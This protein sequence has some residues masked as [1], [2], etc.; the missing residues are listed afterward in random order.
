M[1]VEL[2]V[3]GGPERVEGYTPH[4]VASQGGTPGQVDAAG[5][6]NALQ[7]YMQE[8]ADKKKSTI[9]E[10]S[11]STT[12]AHAATIKSLEQFN[13]GGYLNRAVAA[14]VTSDLAALDAERGGLQL[15]EGLEPEVATL[16]QG[17]LDGSITG[18]DLFRE[19]EKLEL[20]TAMGTADIFMG[21]SDAAAGITT[22]SDY[23][24][25]R[26]AG[27]ETVDPETGEVIASTD[28]WAD[29]GGGQAVA[30]ALGITID[31]LNG[32]SID[33]FQE[34][35]DL[36][37]DAEYSRAG[38]LRAQ[39]ESLP[40]GSAQRESLEVSYKEL[41]GSGVEAAEKA[42]DAASLELEMADQIELP[43]GRTLDFDDLLGDDEMKD[44][45][46]AYLNGDKSVFPED[47]EILTAVK[48][49][50]D[51]YEEKYIE[52]LNASDRAGEEYI[53]IK[54]ANEALTGKLG[55]LADLLP[56]DFQTK[57][58]ADEW[59]AANEHWLTDFNETFTPENQNLLADNR[60]LLDMYMANPEGMSAILNDS[61]AYDPALAGQIANG[62]ITS[63]EELDTAYTKVIVSEMETEDEVFD[64][65][66][67]NLG[68]P[69][70]S[71]DLVSDLKSMAA[72][73]TP[74]RRRKIEYLLKMVGSTGAMKSAIVSGKLGDLTA[75]MKAFLSGY[76]PSVEASTV[77]EE[78]GNDGDITMGEFSNMMYDLQLEGGGYPDHQDPKSLFNIIKG[79]FTRKNPFTGKEEHTPGAFSFKDWE[80]SFDDYSLKRDADGAR[81]SRREAEAATDYENKVQ[82]TSFMDTVEGRA[83]FTKHGIT[84]SRSETAQ[85]AALISE[86]VISQEEMHFWGVDA[87]DLE[88]FEGEKQQRLIDQIANSPFWKKRREAK[89]KRERKF[90]K[91]G[92]K[93]KGILDTK[94][95]DEYSYE[96]GNGDP[97]EIY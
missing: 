50:I 21:L 29:M 91:T 13:Q 51:A 62:T 90:V 53:E 2:N 77:Q 65:I 10:E 5:T 47:S 66:S 23:T 83:A 78:F 54:A 20:P 35:V 42:A 8:Q 56:G 88:A 82:R 25:G 11:E 1:P 46:K 75:D 57:E 18:V 17:Y 32:M 84:S 87:A 14:N 45:I 89:K 16:A 60:T 39:I 44:M 76:T 31:A 19:I 58:E 73:E 27:T 24:L 40:H 55:P 72:F 61:R 71:A 37:I 52:D 22:E 33:Q 67:E 81:A 80:N 41:V 12:L 92:K 63:P 68:I 59:E 4:G 49:H 9:T 85:V 30:D 96:D 48:N 93:K 86:G 70:I 36:R 79:R 7:G 15:M 28:I 64:Y 74:E 38:D 69:G 43:D 6:R 95:R 34:A 26:L 3:D 97:V 94:S